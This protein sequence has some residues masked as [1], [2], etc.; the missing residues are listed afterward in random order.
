[1]LYMTKYDAL[2]KL[3]NSDLESSKCLAVK[4]AIKCEFRRFIAISTAKH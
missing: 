3:V 2:K 1:M 4:R